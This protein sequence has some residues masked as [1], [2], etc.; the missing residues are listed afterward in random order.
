MLDPLIA[1]HRARYAALTRWSR[2]GDPAGATLAARTA[3][4]ARF[5][6]EVDPENQ[7]PEAERGRRALIA[8]RAHFSRMT[9]V[10]V[11]AAS[12]KNAASVQTTEATLGAGRA[13]D[14]QP[15]AI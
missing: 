13:E 12:K 15:V 2:E 4:L 10:R 5:E 3:F 11:T 7:L 1:H 8:R 6:R 14:A 9:L